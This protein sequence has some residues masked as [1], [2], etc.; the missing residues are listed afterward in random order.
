MKTKYVGWQAAS[1]DGNKVCGMTGSQPRWKQSMWDDRQ[2]AKMETKYVG[3]QAASQGEN[4]VCGMAGSQPRWKQNMCCHPFCTWALTH[5][6][7][8]FVSV[9]LEVCLS[10]PLSVFL[11]LSDSSF[12]SPFLSL[13]ENMYRLAYLWVCLCVCL[14][15]CLSLWE[16]KREQWIYFNIRCVLVCLY[17]FML[18]T[19]TDI[20]KV[21]LTGIE[22]VLQAYQFCIRQVSLYGPTNVS[23]IIHHVAR[24]AAHAQ[25]QEMNGCGAAVSWVLWWW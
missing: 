11:C 7:W 20:T 23:P 19:V 21:I 5:W 22:G 1:Q 14:C 9:C 4:K 8:L 12:L 6:L 10:L 15:I 2:P 18:N 17:C 25:Q 13:K 3:W 24:F 16:R